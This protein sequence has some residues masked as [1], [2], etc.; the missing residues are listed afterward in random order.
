MSRI[1]DQ[2]IPCGF[3]GQHQSSVDALSLVFGTDL[4]ICS[5]CVDSPAPETA[6]ARVCSGCRKLHYQLRES[7]QNPDVLLC[8]PCV[9][10]H[11]V[12]KKPTEKAEFCA[13]CLRSKGSVKRLV[14]RNGVFI[15]NECVST[16]AANDQ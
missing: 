7:F 11:K 4:H 10:R 3:C 1:S 12:K 2:Q 14:G 15:C 6:T 8:E 9:D 5:Q 13:F 16:F